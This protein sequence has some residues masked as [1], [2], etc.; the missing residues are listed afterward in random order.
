MQSISTDVL[1]GG[2]QSPRTAAALLAVV[3]AQIMAGTLAAGDRL[4]PVR[5]AAADLDLAPNTVAAAY[6]QLSERGLVTGEGRRGTFVADRGPAE[7]RVTAP[8]GSGLVN[9]ADGNPDHG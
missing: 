4:P 6:R 9:L 3:E 5:A 2:G 1:I 8:I 7:P